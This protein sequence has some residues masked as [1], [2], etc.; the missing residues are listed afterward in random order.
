MG[1]LVAVVVAARAFRIVVLSI[2]LLT[3]H[4]ILSLSEG[5]FRQC[6]TEPIKFG[7]KLMSFQ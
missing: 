1:W 5:E 2:L 3:R 7:L 6:K 4:V